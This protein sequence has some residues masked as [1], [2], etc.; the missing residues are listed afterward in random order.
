MAR[1]L[2]F[3]LSLLLLFVS[4]FAAAATSLDERANAAFS[5]V[6]LQPDQKAPYEAL[7]HEYYQ[8]MYDMVKRASWQNSGEMLQ[9]MVGNRGEKISD[10]T[11]QKAAKFLDDKQMEDL[12]Y[13][14]DLANRSFVETV[15]AQ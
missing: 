1:L 3:V 8:H 5:R 6:Q 7:I 12:R 11:M 10:E 15:G 2:P 4:V 13:A 9:K 14:L